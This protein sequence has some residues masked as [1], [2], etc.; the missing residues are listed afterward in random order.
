MGCQA[1]KEK[2]N[3]QFLFSFFWFSL[4][5]LKDTISRTLESYFIHSKMYVCTSVN[6]RLY[7]VH[8]KARIFF[9]FTLLGIKY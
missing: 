2:C 8:M 5:T 4:N 3:L 9:D 6:F 1:E 7:L